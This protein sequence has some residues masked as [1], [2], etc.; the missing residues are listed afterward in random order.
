MKRFLLFVCVL[1]FGLSVKAQNTE[2]V[3]DSVVFYRNGTTVTRLSVLFP[4]PQT[5]QYQTVHS[6]SYNGGTYC[7][8]AGSGDRYARFQFNNPSGDSVVVGVN[9]VLTHNVINTDFSL[10]NSNQ[11]YDVTSEDYL[12][13]TGA[14][15]GG[16]VDPNNAVIISV[17]DSIWNLSQGIVNYAYNCYDYVAENYSYLNPNTGI[18]PLSAIISAGGGD[19]GNLSSV[20]ISLLR[21][22]G[23]PSRHVVSIFSNG[24]C[25]V[26]AEFKIEGYGWIPVDV[27]YH[28]SNSYG[29]YFGCYN[30]NATVVGYD[31]GHT[32]SRWGEN[33]TYISDILQN[34]HWWWWGNGGTP[35]TGWRISC[36]AT[37]V[38]NGILGLSVNNNNMGQ[39]RGEGT[40][41]Q[42]TQ[43]EIM[44]IPAAGFHFLHWNDNN[45]D[46]PR[47]IVLSSDTSFMAFFDSVSSITV[48]DTVIVAEQPTYYSVNVSSV[49][50]IQGLAAGNG[51]FP[52][53][54]L[55]EIAAIPIEGFRFLQWDDGNTDNPRTI[56]VS[57]DLSF[58]ASFEVSN[59]AINNVDG[60]DF[61]ITTTQGIITVFGAV[62][63]RICLFDSQGRQLAVN[64]QASN[65]Q[66]FAVNAIGAYYIQV[67]KH[68]AR[69][70]VVVK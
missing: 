32:Y 29:N 53:G 26:W 56:I 7:E 68:P 6:V 31:V 21:N 4:I 58:L 1:A 11:P 8:V 36:E 41:I 63:E 22:K 23:I 38:P 16:Y 33:N 12:L 51:S 66:S 14:S 55:V 60:T 64:E 24:E 10:I 46:N 50:V 45:T 5:N 67:G 57:G 42:G 37:T 48:H 25:H 39:T 65:I 49:N 28:Q 35:T 40:Y 54:T 47:S 27:T 3:K 34:Y 18:H 69:K 59:V 2:L 13:Y 52:E 15:A 17:A 43:V 70:V 30:Y 62:G 61:T 19:C 44:A 20:F 9:T